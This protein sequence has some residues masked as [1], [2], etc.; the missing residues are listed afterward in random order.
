MSL[1]G[2]ESVA[3]SCAERWYWGAGVVHLPMSTWLMWKGSINAQ[4]MGVLDGQKTRD[5]LN[6]P[7]LH[8]TSLT[9]I[10]LIFIVKNMPPPNK[11]YTS[12]LPK[13]SQLKPTWLL[14]PATSPG[15]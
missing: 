13:E 5:A 4:E 10:L 6:S 2:S 1:L 8:P 15:P 3:Q 7:L 12:S 11:I 9:P 14:Y